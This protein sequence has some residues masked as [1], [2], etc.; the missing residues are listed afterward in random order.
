MNWEFHAVNAT[1]SKAMI[2][3]YSAIAAEALEQWIEN[4][5][6]ETDK[7]PAGDEYAEYPKG[8]I[9]GPSYSFRFRVYGPGG[10]L[11]PAEYDVKVEQTFYP[12]F[13]KKIWNERS[14]MRYKIGGVD[15]TR[16]EFFGLS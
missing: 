14:P 8:Y 12:I 11:S 10:C 4:A 13:D 6:L 16:K 15:V 7:Q 2:A 3:E 9:H 5:S 1:D